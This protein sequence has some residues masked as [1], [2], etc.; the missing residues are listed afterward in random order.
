MSRIHSSL[1]RSTLIKMGVR[2]AVIIALST[3]F[4][5]LHMFNALRAEALVRLEGHV[6]ERSQREQVIFVLAEDNQRLLRQVLKERLQ[7]LGQEDPSARFD[8]LFQ[9]LPDGSIRDR[10]ERFDGTKMPCVFIPKGVQPDAALRRTLLASY[11]V[12]SQYGPAFLVR[13]KNTYITFPSGAFVSFWPEKPAFCRDVEATFS[14]L[15]FELFSLSTPEHNAR[16]QPAW[17]GIFVEPTAK[18]WMVSAS[19]PV[20]VDGRHVATISHDILLED[21]MDRTLH[22][23]LPG[24]YDILFRDDGQVIAHPALNM[25]G[26]TEGYNILRPPGPRGGATPKFGS[27][28]EQVHLKNIFDRVM[29]R[30]PRENVQEIP[31]QGEY[32]AISVIRGP[33]WNFVTVLPEHQ[34]TSAAFQA[35]RYVLLFGVLSLLLELTV[36][37]WVLREQITRPLLNLTQATTTVASGNFKLQ[38]DTSREDELGQLAQGFQLMAAEVH[39][40]EEALKQANEGLELRVEARTLEL[41]Q[42]HRKLLDTARQVGRAEVATNV[43]HNVGNVLNSVTTA[44][45]L[46]RQRLTGLKFDRLSRV[47]SLC[48]QHQAD[49]ATFLT[50]D[51]RGQN[52][53]P[54]LSRLG[55]HMQEEGQALHVLMGDVSRHTEHIGAIVKL[56]Q[57]YARTPQLLEPV[58]LQELVEDAL[59]INLAAL[60]RHAVKVERSLEP[61]PPVLTEKHKVLMILVNLISN[62]KYALEAVPQDERRMTLKLARSSAG[63]IRIEVQDNGIG[64]A[65]DMQTR[66]F[67]YGF[68][69]REEGHGF[70]LHSSALA[71]Q[72]LGGSLSVQSEGVGQ[73]AAFILDLPAEPQRQSEPTHG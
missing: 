68:T 25:E 44:A 7:G 8:S 34:V 24:A 20:D 71:A 46:A 4:S 62:A 13:F 49:L 42:L 45:M 53:L 28:E 60:G 55:K 33:G 12:L 66:I 29:N 30:A 57:R 41:K 54:F 59:R 64:I 3:F 37:Y 52:V 51:K 10:P 70:G 39:R 38:M 18:L 6:S 47:V 11:D 17:T 61:L 23:Q 35:A 48:E 67:Q 16:R 19:T 69:T 73:G 72:E 36:M 43:L 65:P 32:A 22:N 15:P 9:P 1:A 27:E 58:N 2:I 56:Q 5:Y 40:R 26:A 14:V 31:E 21:L 63:H 50:Q